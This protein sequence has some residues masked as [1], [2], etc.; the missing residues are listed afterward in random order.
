METLATETVTISDIAH[1]G[2]GV[3]VFETEAGEKRLF[4]GGALPG[5]TVRVSITG[6]GVNERGRVEAILEA[7]PDRVEPPCPVFD[8]CGGC[9]LQH[10]DQAPY[11][12]WKRHQVLEAFAD[13][14]L[15][16]EV[17]ETV[18]T[19]PA[20]RRRAVIAVQRQTGSPL[21]GFR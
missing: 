16:V 19:G 14:G 17:A 11:L 20:S 3:A 1:K 15:E 8:R 2:D 21:V 12:A 4:V 18:A 6:E 10:W 13:R 7:S 9:S 5:E